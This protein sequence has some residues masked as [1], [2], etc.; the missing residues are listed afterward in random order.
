[1][2]IFNIAG[3]RKIILGLLVM[4]VGVLV[5]SFAPNGLTNNLLDL[6]KYIGVGFFAG[7]GLEHIANAVKDRQAVPSTQLDQ[8][9]TQLGDI[10]KRQEMTD[11]SVLQ[12]QQALTT[13]LQA[14]QGAG[15]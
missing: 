13:I 4:L 2:K 5:D 14:T 6:L 1:M 10:Q 12:T 9:S 7:N 15:Q 8:I 3:G 11:N